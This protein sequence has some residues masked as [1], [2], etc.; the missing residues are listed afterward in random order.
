MTAKKNIC[1]QSIHRKFTIL[2]EIGRDW[3]GTRGK[4]GANWQG[5]RGRKWAGWGC[6]GREVRRGQAAGPAAKPPTRAEPVCFDAVETACGPV[7][8][9]SRKPPAGQGAAPSGAG[10]RKNGVRTGW[11]R[12]RRGPARRG[13]KADW[14]R[15]RKGRHGGARQGSCGRCRAAGRHRR[16]PQC[17]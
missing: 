10:M 9:G 5:L 12:P 14:Q 8:A 2:G 1:T 15:G 7:P 16:Q 17:R 11:G 13:R 6:R 3:V 4:P